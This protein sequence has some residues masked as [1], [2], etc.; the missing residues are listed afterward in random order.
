MN[1]VACKTLADRFEDKRRAGLID[2]K[3]LLRNSQEASVEEVCGEVSAFYAAI[4]QGK[5]KDLDFGD[6]RWNE[7]GLTAR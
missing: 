1:N 6:M 5:V 4:D 3:F 2:V 7:A